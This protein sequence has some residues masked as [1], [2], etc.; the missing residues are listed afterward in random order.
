M[1]T[2]ILIQCLTRRLD[3]IVNKPADKLTIEVILYQIFARSRASC[4]DV[5][6]NESENAE[7]IRIGPPLRKGG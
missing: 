5:F 6:L 7:I 3:E 2:L 4:D 1:I